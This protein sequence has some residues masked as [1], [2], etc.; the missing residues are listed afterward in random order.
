MPA[1]AFF[2]TSILVYIVTDDDRR[3]EIAANSLKSGGSVSVQILNEFVN[4]IRRKYR[5][6]WDRLGRALQ[7]IRNSSEAV[8]PMTLATHEEG[9]RIA[10]RYG[11]RIYDSLVIASA[12][13]AGCATLYSED[14]QDGQTIG[15]VTIR[16]PFAGR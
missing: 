8:L 11:Y 14:M 1:R 7:D 2:D 3:S 16:N 13:E 4:V 9:L 12:I 10:Q 15:S 5:L 6:D